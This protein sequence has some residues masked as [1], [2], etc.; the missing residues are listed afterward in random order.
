[1]SVCGNPTE[2]TNTHLEKTLDQHDKKIAD[3]ISKF[4][5]EASQHKEEFQT[6][7]SNAAIGV[8]LGE[9]QGRI[10]NKL[11]TYYKDIPIM[12]ESNVAEQR[13]ELKPNDSDD[14]K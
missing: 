13:A 7:L 11:D 9:A 12:K 2:Q 1:M 4:P 14:E 10:S 5:E 3:F 8:T 6:Q